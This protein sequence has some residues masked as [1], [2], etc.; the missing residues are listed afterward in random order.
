MTVNNPELLRRARAYSRQQ[1]D[2][3]MVGAATPQG[4]GLER[5]GAPH[6]SR[7]AW[8]SFRATYGRYPS[9]KDGDIPNLAG[10]P[11]WAFELMGM[12]PPPV[13]VT[14]GSAGASYPGVNDLSIW[15]MK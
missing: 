15:R 2:K 8:E 11:D 7:D 5:I 14:T 12:K 13:D 6:W 1:L 4:A 9:F 10:C 3:Q